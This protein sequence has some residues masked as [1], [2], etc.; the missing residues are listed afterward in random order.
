VPFLAL[1]L[2]SLPVVGCLALGSLEWRYPPLKSRPAHAGA[3]VVLSAGI[4]PADDVRL[5][6]ELSDHSLFRCL[7]AADLYRQGPPIPVLVTG[8]HADPRETALPDGVLMSEFLERQGLD[9][10][11][12]IVEAE[13]RSTYENA[14][15]CRKLLERRRIRE[16]IVV[17]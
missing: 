6:D 2:I 7:H 15:E 11:D 14:L 1:T 13:A 5:R 9:R 10:A 4:K 8:G 3:I 17:T 12:L 16:I